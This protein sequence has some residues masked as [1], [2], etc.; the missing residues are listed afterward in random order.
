M[1]FLTT[2][3]VDVK[4][5]GLSGGDGWGQE[6]WWDLSGLLASRRSARKIQF[7]KMEMGKLDV[8]ASGRPVKTGVIDDTT[9][10]T[11]RVRG[12]VEVERARPTRR[13]PLHPKQSLSP[14]VALAPS[15][16]LDPIRRCI[17][18]RSLGTRDSS[19]LYAGGRDRI[20]T[21]DPALIKRML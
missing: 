18:K 17:P 8:F 9:H 6:I 15:R 20:R 10:K 21:C 2:L 16:G 7:P 4:E 12:G 11:L 3:Y 13:H 14:P 1:F 19:L 5:P